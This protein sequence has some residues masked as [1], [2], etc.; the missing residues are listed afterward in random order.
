MT[1]AGRPRRP[2]TMP[3][4]TAFVA[5]V[6]AGLALPAALVVALVLAADWWLG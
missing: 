6:A 1:R 3:R 4:L 2:D 5:G